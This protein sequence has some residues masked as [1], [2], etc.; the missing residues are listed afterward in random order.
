MY[1]DNRRVRINRF[2][3]VAQVRLIA[4]DGTMIGV[5]PILEAQN[6]AR[7]AGLDLVEIAPMANPPVCKIMDFSKYLYELD[8]QARENR[9]K[10]KAGVLKEI[11][12][13]PRIAKHDLETKIKHIETF[14]KEQN[15]VRVTVVFHGRENQHRNLGEAIL[16]T[17][18]NN[19]AA[20]GVVEGRTQ[21]MGN[22]MSIMLTPVA[23]AAVKAAPAA[24][25]APAAKTP[26]APKQQ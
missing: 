7:G 4:T 24:P 21:M 16:M 13:N 8:K 14:L 22:R 15:K 5:K 25:K 23:P 26:E 11:R 12:F 2:I 17:V 9:K 20:V 19:L 6:M 10:Q 1:H 18:K 3:N